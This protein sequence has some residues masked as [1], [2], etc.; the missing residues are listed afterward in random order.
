MIPDEAREAWNRSGAAHGCPGLGD[1]IDEQLTSR[2]YT[3]VKVT[4]LHQQAS[5][6]PDDPEVVAR[7]LGLVPIPD[8][9]AL[10]RTIDESGY[11]GDAPEAAR[12]V[13]ALLRGE[14]QTDG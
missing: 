7:R 5:A 1:Q 8:E 9:A 4:D 14:G 12:A 10:T 2:G 11:V 13:L 6:I 3:V